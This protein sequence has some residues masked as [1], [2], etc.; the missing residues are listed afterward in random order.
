MTGTGR[1]VRGQDIPQHRAGGAALLDIGRQRYQVRS[2]LGIPSNHW[3][4]LA[5]LATHGRTWLE[6]EPLMDERPLG[7]EGA[8]HQ[9]RHQS[10]ALLASLEA[11]SYSQI[12]V[13]EQ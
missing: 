3:P 4:L 11:Q 10:W 8:R 13:S 9:P 12:P 2:S 6:S 5:E 7:S 1:R